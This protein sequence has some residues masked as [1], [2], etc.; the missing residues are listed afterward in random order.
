MRKSL[1]TSQVA[2]S[3]AFTKM[4]RTM[5]TFRP[6]M[7]PPMPSYCII[8]L[9]A[10]KNPYCFFNEFTLVFGLCQIVD[11]PDFEDIAWGSN[12]AANC[13]GKS[14]SEKFPQETHFLYIRKEISFYCFENPYSDCGI[15]DLTKECCRNSAIKTQKYFGQKVP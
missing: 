12:D 15:S 10:S 7:N 5:L 1:A 4:A 11:E 3:P 9:Q 6:F 8:L 14:S 2:S 13:A